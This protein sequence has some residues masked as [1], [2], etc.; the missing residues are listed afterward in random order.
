MPPQPWRQ[1]STVSLSMVTGLSW[2]K[3]AGHFMARSSSRLFLVEHTRKTAGC[4]KI[5][6]KADGREKARKSLRCALATE[7]ERGLSQAA[8]AAEAGARWDVPWRGGIADPLRS[9]TLRGP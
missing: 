6:H 4:T 7:S 8:A 3:Q 2:L 9:G 5:R 1:T